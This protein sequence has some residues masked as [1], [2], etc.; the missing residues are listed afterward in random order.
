MPTYDKRESGLWSVRFRYYEGVEEHFKRLSGY[1]TKKAA[2]AAYA[3][4]VTENA[5]KRQKEQTVELFDDLV[6]AYLDNLQV[7]ESSRL[8]YENRVK[9]HILPFFMGK[10]VREIKPI[11][12]LAWQKSLSGYA[13]GYKKTLR[14]NLHTIFRFGSQYFGT[15]NPVK[16]VEGFRDDSEKVK[17]MKVWSKDQYKEFLSVVDDPT[18]HALFR[19][20]YSS[21][22]RLGEALALQK[23]DV[24]ALKCSVSVNKTLSRKVKDKGY[25]LTTPKNKYSTR[26]IDLSQSLIAELLS[27]PDGEFVFG[28]DK[29]LHENTVRNRLIAY[30]KKTDLPSIRV[31]DFRHSHVSFLL[32]NHVSITAVSKRLGHKNSQITLSIYAHLM[33]EDTEQIKS[34]IT[35]I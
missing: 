34:A 29:P 23:K 8:A 20:L 16:D 21:G 5:V 27:L 19:L 11:D 13:Y 25:K 1:K 30:T 15:P 17:E 26:K 14:G 22:L 24:D 2:E 9:N 31:H 32:S 10:K 28:G 35:E 3:K 12:I 33:P 4:F 18:Y 7:K 6:V